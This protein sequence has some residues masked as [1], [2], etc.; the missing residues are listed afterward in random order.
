MITIIW[1]TLIAFSLWFIYFF[2][3]D[4]RLHKNQLGDASWVKTAFIGFLVNFFDVLGIGAFAPQTALLKFTKQT[5][6]RLIPGTMNVAN[7]IPVLIQAIVFIQIIEV[8]PVT[9]LVMFATAT[10]GATVGAGFVSKLSENKIRLTMSIALLITAGFMF[11]NKMN[12]IQGQGNAIGLHGWKLFIAAAVNFILGA[13]MTVGVGLYAPCMAMVFLLGLS[14]LVAF[15]IMMGSCAFLMPPASFKFIKAGAYHR[16]AALGMALAGTVAVLIAAF[17]VKS[18]PLDTLKWIVLVIVLYTSVSML[19]NTIQV[20]RINK[21]P[22]VL[23]LVLLASA[24]ALPVDARPTKSNKNYS[25]GI[26]VESVHCENQNNPIGIDDANPR[27]GWIIKSNAGERGQYQ[28][29]YQIQ[30]ASSLALLNAGKADLWDSRIIGNISSNNISYN[31]KPLSSEKRYYWRV[32]IWDKR[33]KASSWSNPAFWEMGL[34]DNAEWKGK[35]IEEA[36]ASSEENKNLYEDK[37]SP[38]FRKD[39]TLSRKIKK[40]VMH[41]SGIGYYEAFLNGKKVGNKLLDPGWTDYSK[42]ILY[43]TYDVTTY[44]ATG[45]NCV[46]MILGNG[47]YNP[48]PM[49]MWGRRNIREALPAGEPK[50]IMQLNIE[51]TDGTKQ[52]VVS[53]NT[54]KVTAGPILRNNIY[55]GE[56]YDAR[57]EIPGWCT[58]GLNTNDWKLARI[59]AEPTGKLCSEQLPPIVAGDTILPISIKKLE[60]GRFIVDFG[61]NFGGIIRLEAKGASGTVINLSYGELLYANGTLNVMTS[62]AG[63]IKRKGV[64]GEGS[65]DTAFA[66]DQFILSGKMKDVFQPKFTFH[67]FRYV[68]VSGF[69]GI[70]HSQDIKGL[71]LFSNV[72]DAGA[73]SCSDSTL[74]QIQKISLN[75]FRS[76]IF[77]V[78]SDCPHRERFAYGGDIVAT[79]E[80]FMY[81]YNMSGFYEKTVIDFAD[82]AQEDGGLTETAPFVGIASDG[83]GGKS[84]PV[85]WGSAHPILLY[86]LYQYYGKIDLLREQYPVVKNWVDFM[87]RNAKEGIINK[88][89]GDHESIDE[90]VVGLSATAYYY[91]N[92]LLLAKFANLLDRKDDFVKYNALKDTIKAAFI[93]KYYDPATGNIDIHTAAAQSFGLYFN[94]IPENAFDAAL[95]VLLEN[96]SKNDDHITAGIFGTKFI[97]EVLSRTG[98]GSKAYKMATQKTYPGWGY[99]LAN[100]ATTLWEQWSMSENTYSH[101]HPMFG[102]ISEWFYKYLAGIQPANDAVGYNKIIIRPHINDLQWAKASYNSVLGKTVSSWKITGETVTLDI[103]IPVNATATVYLPTSLKNIKERGMA[104]SDKG[105]VQFI[106]IENKESK[107]VLGSGNYQFTAAVTH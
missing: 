33:K 6:D 68:E 9:L 100:G 21:S 2:A 16:K 26:N 80:A 92:T 85:E 18:L 44:M 65:P 41:V 34:L 22:F 74:N 55:L 99:M 103:T 49:K 31:G 96:I 20:S 64:G 94:L 73:F 40:A 102:S 36:K 59:A 66:K 10:I 107:F 42:R 84:G 52:E 93:S 89:I 98:N 1:I 62:T 35:W 53:D 25:P 58:T 37:P 67:G 11:A 61:K 27:L 101:N 23:F 32:K 12:W 69:P 48:L 60:E 95:K 88:T 28:T 57:K 77:S 82:E 38:L 91:Y 75:T 76:N 104:I 8:D 5:P 56:K 45:S 39:F 86:H 97:L 70:L 54:W 105:D 15:P 106:G 72:P 81:N 79:C 47:W 24:F 14:P 50:F 30:V 29:A 51:F 46:G 17:I 19:Y 71:V 63:Q 4:I 13:M 3:I 43:S 87:S 7:T 90:K 83:L 78:Q